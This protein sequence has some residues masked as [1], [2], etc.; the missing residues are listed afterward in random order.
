MTTKEQ[1]KH[2]PGPWQFRFT[3]DYVLSSQ[4]RNPIYAVNGLEGDS[5]AVCKAVLAPN[6]ANARLIAAAPELL[7]ALLTI[8]EQSWMLPRNL[9]EA[10][11][12]KEVDTAIAKATGE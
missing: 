9:R 4:G 12:W 2:T 10:D 3:K 5:V 7:K 1:A 6:E 8:Q 11:E